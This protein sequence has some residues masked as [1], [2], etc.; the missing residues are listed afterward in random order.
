VDQLQQ[1]FVGLLIGSLGSIEYM[2]EYCENVGTNKRYADS[3]GRRMSKRIAQSA[4]KPRPQSLSPEEAGLD[5]KPATLAKQ[6]VAV[7]A[8]VT[9]TPGVILVEDAFAMEWNDRAVRIE[10]KNSD[11]SN[12]SCWVYKGA[13]SPR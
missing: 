9:V 7:T 3:V 12:A 2:F 6:P 5:S 4:L 13:I 11:G 8:W 10:W 1:L